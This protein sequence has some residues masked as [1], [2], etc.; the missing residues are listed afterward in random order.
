MRTRFLL[1]AAFLAL[2]TVARPQ[3]L[4]DHRDPRSSYYF[5]DYRARNVGDLL[6][7]TIEE[8]T[9]SDAQEKRDLDKQTKATGSGSGTGS[10]SSLG[11]VLRSFAADIN[12]NS[13][14][15]RTFGGK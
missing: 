12:L 15:Q 4:W 3:T 5:H 10:S 1:F 9:G 6:T 2:P 11:T 8:T 14:S 13:A 7:I